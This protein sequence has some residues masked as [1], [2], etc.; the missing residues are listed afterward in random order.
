MTDTGT[1]QWAL[2]PEKLD[3]AVQRLVAVAD[4]VRIVLFGSRARG[5]ADDFSDLDLLI[6]ERE[7]AD[8][9]QELQRL[10]H[11]L[12]GMV[13]PVDLLVISEPDYRQW[14]QTPGSIYYAAAREGRILYEAA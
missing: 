1:P 2:T 7:V 6:V 10:S 12:L 5:D 14:S 9:Y 3:E 11:A 8:R 4:P 13:L